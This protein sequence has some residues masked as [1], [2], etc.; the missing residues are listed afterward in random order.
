MKNYY[1]FPK[2]GRVIGFIKDHESGLIRLDLSWPGFDRFMITADFT[3][4][5]LIKQL[6]EAANYVEKYG[7][8]KTN[9]S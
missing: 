2:E 6:R 7:L 8:G 3:P 1:I 9:K 4:D 5:D